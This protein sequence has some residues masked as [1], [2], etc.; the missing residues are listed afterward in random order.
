MDRIFEWMIKLLF[1]VILTPILVGIGIGVL[2]IILPWLLLLSVIAGAAAGLSAGLILRRRLLPP[3]QGDPLPPGGPP[4]GPWGVRRP[5][6]G[7]ISR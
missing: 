4:L 7:R 2:A 5:R 6:S 1:L 3:G